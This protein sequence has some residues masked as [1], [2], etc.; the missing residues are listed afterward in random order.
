MNLLMTTDLIKIVSGLHGDWW[1]P[2]I[3]KLDTILIFLGQDR[4]KLAMKY[5]DFNAKVT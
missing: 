4:L 1:R 5:S 3:W 2:H